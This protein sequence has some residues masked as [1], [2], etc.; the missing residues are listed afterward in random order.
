MRDFAP[1]MVDKIAGVLIGAYSLA[2]EAIRARAD[3]AGSDPDPDAQ[4]VPLVRPQNGGEGSR[5][6]FIV[7]MACD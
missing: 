6:A 3:T 4:A 1:K 2:R 5:L 7:L